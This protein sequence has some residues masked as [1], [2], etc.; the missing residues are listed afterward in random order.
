MNK[1]ELTDW[2]HNTFWPTYRQFLETPK[3]NQWGPGARGAS[4]AKIIR[5]NPSEELRNTIM[6]SLIAQ[7][8]HRRVLADKLGYEAYE[9]HAAKNAKGGESVYKNRQATTWLQNMGWDD[10]I[11][12]IMEVE[13]RA[14]RKC[15][16]GEDTMGPKIPF[17]AEHYT[18]GMAKLRLVK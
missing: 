15:H 8:R 18:D 1:Q 2:H 10:E 16:C 3:K 7:M 9:K 4:L 13:Q 11:P 14:I 12:S 5:L 6:G 17:C